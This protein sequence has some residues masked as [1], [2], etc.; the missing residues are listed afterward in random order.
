MLCARSYQWGLIW[1]LQYWQWFGNRPKKGLKMVGNY[2]KIEYAYTLLEPKRGRIL[3]EVAYVRPFQK[4]KDT[5]FWSWSCHW[6][7]IGNEKLMPMGDNFICLVLNEN[8]VQIGENTFHKRGI[9]H[10]GPVPSSK[11]NGASYR[12]ADNN[13]WNL[14]YAAHSPTN[15]GT[16]RRL[17][18]LT[19]RFF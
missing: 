15:A 12:L 4:G 11:A 1:W 8:R 14:S 3:H 7:K 10:P 19:W 9:C 16:L 5:E 13:F 17:V 2:R 18:T 6:G